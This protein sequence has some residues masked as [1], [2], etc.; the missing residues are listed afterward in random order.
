MTISATGMVSG[1]D[2]NSIIE[3]LMEV[4]RKPIYRKEHEIERSEQIGELWREVNTVM[5]TFKRT[6]SPLQAE[7]TFTAPVPESSNEEVLTASVSGNPE[8]G[9]HRFD[10]EQLATNHSVASNPE[11]AGDLIANPNDELG[12]EGTFSLGIGTPLESLQNFSFAEETA[13]WL[14][15][16]FGS[17]FQAVVSGDAED[18]YEL[19]P[20]ELAFA[21]DYEEQGAEKIRV[22][23]DDFT[24]DAG[25][26]LV[27]ELEEYF[28]DKGWDVDL[29]EPLFE[30]FK[31]E[32]NDEWVARGQDGGQFALAGDHPLGKFDLR[33]EVLNEDDEVIAV[34]NFS[35]DISN[36]LDE[37]GYINVEE[38][39]SL[40]DIVDRINAQSADTGVHASL[41]MA[42][43]GDYRLVLESSEEGSE[44]YIQ[45]FDLDGDT[46]L[47]DLQLVG[48]ESSVAGPHYLY[49]PQEAQDARFTLNGLEMTRSSNTFTDAVS[50]VEINL[51]DE[52]TSTVE[53][54]PDTE[55]A[56]EEVS[57]F[58]DAY[59]EAHNFLRRLQEEDDGPLQGSGD[60]MRM[61]RQLRTLIH[62][63]VPEFDGSTHSR[64]SFTYD[65]VGEVRARGSGTYEGTRGELV[66]E[67]NARNNVWRHDGRNVQSGDE[68][69]GI[70]IEIEEDEAN[71]PAGGDTLTLEVSPASEP[72]KYNSL[73]A[74][75][76]SAR[77][78]A[79]E[80]E[81]DQTQLEDALREDPDSVHRLFAREAPV[82]S[83]G[84]K[85]AP[86]GIAIQLE[87]RLNEFIGPGGLVQSR[88]AALQRDMQQAAERIEM[89]EDRM[90][91]REN[92]LIRQ[93][94]FMEQYI[95]RM[96]EQTG[97]IGSLEA[98]MQ[99]E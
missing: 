86:D 18:T 20:D 89:L 28:D 81:L 73:S 5:D 84:R 51:R 37:T 54:S 15:G 30:I 67:Y 80:L 61:E 90:E 94:T 62:S 69:E 91:M 68:V 93:F 21:G 39:D 17:G 95:A 35:L 26:D 99:Q 3:Q 34:E 22:Y 31:D 74:I 6:V 1:L 98:G 63:Q 71:P 11:S 46:V 85:R 75:G 78:E 16:N 12:L 48:E 36:E 66:L 43:E 13:Q 10:V 53:I 52:G 32:E 59:N 92:R 79:G 49:E 42:A 25:E 4:E 58:V 76:I 97:L 23:M 14:H 47:Q 9:T 55:A 40:G 38:D 56:A 19:K 2:V 8:S 7:E 77:D 87:D 27:E 83:A 65:G 72:I 70:E 50:G 64:D 88:E 96:Q 82:N 41:V 24:D 57:L 29:D 33:G 45:A 44:G 60:L